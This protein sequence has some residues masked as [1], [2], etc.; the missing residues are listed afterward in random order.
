MFCALRFWRRRKFMVPR[1][2]RRGRQADSPYN[3]GLRACAS[4]V[5]SDTDDYYYS[6]LIRSAVFTPGNLGGRCCA[7]SGDRAA[8]RYA[9]RPISIAAWARSP[10]SFLPAMR[11][12][13][14]AHAG[15][16]ARLFRRIRAAREKFFPG[17]RAVLKAQAR[18]ATASAAAIASLSFFASL[19]LPYLQVL[20]LPSGP[21]TLGGIRL[22]FFCS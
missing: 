13:A 8:F 12:A 6:V 17:R 18:I 19:F 10:A 21:W 2:V 14:P 1:T 15:K 11:R 5:L 9:L 7:F 22:D 16:G 4:I 20:T 3:R